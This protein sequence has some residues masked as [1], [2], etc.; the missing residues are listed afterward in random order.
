[1][2]LIQVATSPEAIAVYSL[3]VLGIEKK[4]QF[5]KPVAKYLKEGTAL[6]AP[7]IQDGEKL[8]GEVMHAPKVAELEA[9]LSHAE[10]QLSDN[11]LVQLAG[12]VLHALGK[13]LDELT[14]NQKTGIALVISTE[15]AK[16]GLTVTQSAVLAAL[17][18]ADK[19][20][21]VIGSLPLFKSAKEIDA[22][23]SPAP[24]QQEQNPPADN[25]QAPAA[26][27]S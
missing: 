21:D 11:K 7:V 10:S 5:I 3:V 2:N 25:G 15:A 26:A 19:A 27:V 20:V 8:A 14:T 24:V 9:K 18:T 23:P 1:M 4:C 16:A 13:R 12:Q 17:A 6:L 22:A